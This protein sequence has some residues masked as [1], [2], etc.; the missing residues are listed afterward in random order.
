[1]EFSLLNVGLDGIDF[2]IK[3]AHKRKGIIICLQWLREFGRTK[4]AAWLGCDHTS[5]LFCGRGRGQIL[6]SGDS[7]GNLKTSKRDWS[8]GS[9]CLAVVVPQGLTQLCSLLENFGDPF[10]CKTVRDTQHGNCFSSCHKRDS[11]NIRVQF[12]R[13]LLDEVSKWFTAQLSNASADQQTGTPHGW[14]GRHMLLR[15]EGYFLN[16][17]SIKLAHSLS[18]LVYHP[19]QMHVQS[20]WTSRKMGLCGDRERL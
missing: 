7:C 17:K 14:P 16:R 19:W 10:P 18:W 4:I 8:T 15:K 5:L 20:L 11:K 1:M 13:A 12:K 6:L 2:T 9:S 3:V